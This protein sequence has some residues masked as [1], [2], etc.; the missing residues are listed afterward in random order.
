MNAKLP[1]LPTLYLAPCRPF[2]APVLA[3]YLHKDLIALARSYRLEAAVDNGQ[4]NAPRK[5]LG[6]SAFRAGSTRDL[7]SLAR[8]G[9]PLRADYPLKAVTR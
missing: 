2:P 6:K 4:N 5:T 8:A 9:F 3:Q 1:P 7:F